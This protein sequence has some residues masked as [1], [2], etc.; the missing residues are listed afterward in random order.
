MA[1]S[2]SPR[3]LEAPRFAEIGVASAFSFLRGASRPEE[4]VVTAKRLGLAGLGLADRKVAQGSAL[5]EGRKW[6]TEIAEI[7]P[8]SLRMTKSAIDAHARRNWAEGAE[9][10]QFF[11]AKLL[12]EGG[13]GA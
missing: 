8:M 1:L 6:A 13:G 12:A 9:S 11:L 10:D 7:P 2:A 3:P 4:L 5:D